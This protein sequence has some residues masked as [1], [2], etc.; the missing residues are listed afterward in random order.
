MAFLII[1]VLAIILNTNNKSEE[2]IALMPFV[3][4]IGYGI[5]GFGYSL[6]HPGW[7]IFLLIPVIAILLEGKQ[8]FFETL[9]ALS[10]FI[11][12]AVFFLYLSSNGYNQIGWLIFLS[13]PFLAALLEETRKAIVIELLL[14]GGVVGYL[15]IGNEYGQYDIAL[16]AFLPI[17]AYYA[18]T[19]GTKFFR[20]PKEYRIVI[21][22]SVVGYIGLGL[23]SKIIGYDIWSWAWLLFLLIP[24]YAIYRETK[25]GARLIALSPF[26]SLIIFYTLG[27]FFELWQYSWMSF[28]LIPVIAIIKSD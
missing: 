26:I 12:V 4:V 14:I 15:L 21:F 17:T 8:K 10:P 5:L 18:F 1:P 25:G 2:L 7:L 9:V 19:N 11:S 6:W 20:I 23:L 3:A 24:C 16:V 28:L 13:V 27:Y 22:V